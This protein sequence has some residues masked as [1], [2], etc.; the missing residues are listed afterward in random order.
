LLKLLQEISAVLICFRLV[1]ALPLGGRFPSWWF[2]HRNEEYWGV[3]CCWQP[4]VV[5]SQ[6]ETVQCLHKS[7]SNPGIGGS[8][9]WQR[10]SYVP[11]EDL[12]FKWIAGVVV[13]VK[14]GWLC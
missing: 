13:K 2:H 11:L 1:F 8:A 5:G 12:I 4:L 7:P 6:V 10:S 3:F 14:K 9:L